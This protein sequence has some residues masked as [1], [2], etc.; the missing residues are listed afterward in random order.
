M[1]LKD[2]G[3]QPFPEDGMK[4]TLPLAKTVIYSQDRKLVREKYIKN[5][6]KNMTLQAD[7]GKSFGGK[8]A[9]GHLKKK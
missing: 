1:Y 9:L 2:V 8:N 6:P 4:Q 3:A 7:N 5:L